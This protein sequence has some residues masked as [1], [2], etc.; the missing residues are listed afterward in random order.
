MMPR[1]SSPIIEK[2]IICTY[3]VKR[4]DVQRNLINC[5]CNI[6]TVFLSLLS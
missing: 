4:E 1:N 3:K 2:E 5:D 6:N